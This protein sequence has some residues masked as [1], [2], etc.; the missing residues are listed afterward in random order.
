MQVDHRNEISRVSAAEN[1]DSPPIHKFHFKMSTVAR[2]SRAQNPISTL[3]WAAPAAILLTFVCPFASEPE[4]NFSTHEAASFIA[5][6]Q[7]WSRSETL[8]ACRPVPLSQTLDVRRQA[9]ESL[10]VFGRNNIHRLQQKRAA[11]DSA[12][13]VSAA[14]DVW[15][16]RDE[17]PA[18]LRA[19]VWAATVVTAVACAAFAASLDQGQRYRRPARAGSKRWAAG[20]A[21]QAGAAVWAGTAEVGS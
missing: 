10:P 11:S 17:P 12:C 18:A 4:S 13:R 3:I 5:H 6:P 14:N 15:A 8:D 16:G 7:F 9:D 19:A 20:W 2:R 1:S 21:E